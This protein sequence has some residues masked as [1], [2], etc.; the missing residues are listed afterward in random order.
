MAAQ[1]LEEWLEAAMDRASQQA[2][3]DLDIA[4]TRR[5]LDLARRRDADE[6]D[7]HALHRQLTSHRLTTLGAASRHEIGGI[8]DTLRRRVPTGPSRHLHTW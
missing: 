4:D 3:S 6:K 7:L 1:G 5:A 8:A 2:A